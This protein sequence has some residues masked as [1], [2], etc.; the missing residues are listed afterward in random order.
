M[1]SLYTF[2][3]EI[4]SFFLLYVLMKIP[5]Y[6]SAVCYDC[7][8][9]YSITCREYSKAL[10]SDLHISWGNSYTSYDHFITKIMCHKSFAMIEPQYSRVVVSFLPAMQLLGEFKTDSEIG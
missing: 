8:S 1:N 6:L 10:Q 3:A 4:L 9:R 7:W 5:P 2:L